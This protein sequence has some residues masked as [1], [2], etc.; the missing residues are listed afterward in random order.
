MYTASLC[1][2][3][4]H[5][6]EEYIL[7][8]STKPSIYWNLQH[9]KT[10]FYDQCSAQIFLPESCVHKCDIARKQSVCYIW[11]GICSSWR[12][13]QTRG[14]MRHITRAC[15]IVHVPTTP[16][17]MQ[18]RGA[19]RHITHGIAR[20]SHIVPTQY[21]PIHGRWQDAIMYITEVWC[22]TLLLE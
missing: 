8:F 21:P 4:K 17:Y 15:H 13:P 7:R 19:M 12:I 22:D 20:E 2:A 9:I 14:A 6:A 10:V 1:R 16:P 5:H 18:Y 3:L 11:R